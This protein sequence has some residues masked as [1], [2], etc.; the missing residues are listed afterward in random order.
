MV[1]IAFLDGIEAVGD[2]DATGQLEIVALKIHE[3]NGQQC[4]RGSDV[5]IDGWSFFDA[6]TFGLV[7]VICADHALRRFDHL[8]SFD[9]AD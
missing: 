7:G 8:P 6:G 3:R 1:G 5:E 2:G 4:G 9:E